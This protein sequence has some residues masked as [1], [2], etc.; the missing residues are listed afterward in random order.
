MPALVT[1]MNAGVKVALGTDAHRVASYNPFVVLQWVLDGR[2]I[3]G[4]LLRVASE[5]PTR[6]QALRMYTLNAAWFSFDENRRGSLEVGKLADFSIL[7]QDYFSVPVEE[8]GNTTS[9]MTVVGG[10]VVYTTLDN[11][12][13]TP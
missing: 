7:S 9:V 2:A 11:V 10:A 4:T 1:G 12:Q 6:D 13:I 3:D 8:I 5:I